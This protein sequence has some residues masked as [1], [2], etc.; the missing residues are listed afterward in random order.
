MW[1]L[2]VIHRISSFAA[3]AYYR[4]YVG[5]ERVPSSGP[6]LLVA[7][8]PNSLFD[9][10]LVAS[11]AGRPIRFLAKEPLLHH[12]GIGWL[13]RGAG[14]IPIY[15]RSD[16]AA[17]V[18]L[19]D[20]SFRAAHQALEDGAA[21]GMFPEGISHDLPGLAPLKTGAAR[22]AL[23]G[24]RLVGGAFPIIPVGLTFRG[25]EHFRS[26][27]LALVGSP[28][29]WDDLAAAEPAP[30]VTRELTGRIA[31]ALRGQTLNLQ[32]WEDAPL[33]EWAAA[34]YAAEVG[35][36]E[37]RAARMRLEREAVIAL[38]RLRDGHTR[39]LP[40]IVAEVQEHARVLKS[41]GL[42][43]PDLRELPR[44][45][46][47]AVWTARQ[48]AVLLV[49]GALGFVGHAIFYIPAKLA[50]RAVERIRPTPDIRSTYRT[51]AGAL[52]FGIWILLLA[53]ATWV[54][55]GS[56]AAL[57]ALLALPALALTTVAFRDQWADARVVARRFLLL[58]SR[59]SLHRELAA[60]QAWIA[61]RLRAVHAALSS[62]STPA[63][64]TQ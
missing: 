21:I 23:G 26:E 14:S 52:F 16:D 7:N 1:L 44:M 9:P 36:G 37:G 57:L 15:R 62:R 18:H 6:V 41:F 56:G 32:S 40:G 24:A 8:H 38:D 48:S 53:S 30:R 31:A 25:K 43:P 33:V 45:R 39:E 55:F 61:A 20:R 64:P 5:G 49:T 51:L 19:N 10:A 34:I 12:P 47:A 11:A 60:R 28:I 22:I 46:D 29:Q 17:R 42:R 4:L 58:R 59:R 3:R 2:P 35:A 27:A 50:F 13:V 54:A 63:A